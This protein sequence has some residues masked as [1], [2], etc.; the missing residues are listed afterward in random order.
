MSLSHV[1]GQYS[2]F[3]V[4]YYVKKK[5]LKSFIVLQVSTN[6]AIKKSLYLT[7]L[8]SQKSEYGF[9]GYSAEGFKRLHSG[10]W[11]DNREE[12]ASKIIW[13]TGRSHFLVTV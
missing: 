7:V 5:K 8:V 12:S 11:P 4:R 1:Y 13:V 3:L 6:L 9:T 2:I 10:S